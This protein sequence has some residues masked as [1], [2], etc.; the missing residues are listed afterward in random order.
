M[1]AAFDCLAQDEPVAAKWPDTLR[2]AAEIAARQK[3]RS[4]LSMRSLFLYL[5]PE[6]RVRG[7]SPVGVKRERRV[8]VG[9]AQPHP[10]SSRLERLAYRLTA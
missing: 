2:M 6:H 10:R 5:N 8:L 4:S 3:M 7:S 1:R 9:G